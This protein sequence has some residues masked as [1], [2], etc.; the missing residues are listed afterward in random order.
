MTGPVLAVAQAPSRPG[1]VPENLRLA[2]DM[3]GQAAQAGADYVVFP[4]LFLC[5]YDIPG[6]L[7]NPDCHAIAPDPMQC[8]DLQNACARSRIAAVV[9]GAFTVPGGL[10]NGA[11]VIARDGRILHLYSKVHLWGKEKSAFVAGQRPSLLVFPD[12]RIGL[13]ICFDAGFPEHMRGLTLAGADVIVC[14]AAFADGPERHRY[15][16]YFP[17]RALENTVFVAVANAAGEQGG[18]EMF[19][20]SLIADPRGVERARIR[21][22]AGIATVRIDRAEIARARE[23]LPYLSSL[24]G[25][26]TRPVTIE[27]S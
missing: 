4:E 15:E 20:E 3:I 24:T 26:E 10:A 23:E 19:G 16:L 21:S 22:R 18:A 9:G 11:L 7:A 12:I 14:P 6:I 8:S 2:A 5:G 17:I 25:E 1:Q 27:W 13:S